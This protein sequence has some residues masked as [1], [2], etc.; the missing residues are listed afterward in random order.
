MV[1]NLGFLT[2]SDLKPEYQSLYAK[3][4]TPKL[5]IAEG[6]ISRG[7]NPVYKSKTIFPNTAPKAP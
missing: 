1:S 4:E 7:V 2:L 5:M 3:Y 6:I